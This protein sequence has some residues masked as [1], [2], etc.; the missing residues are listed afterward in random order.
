M[1][2]DKKWSASSCSVM[3]FRMRKTK[4]LCSTRILRSPVQL[5]RADTKWSPPSSSS[6]WS[7]SINPLITECDRVYS[8][9]SNLADPLTTIKSTPNTTNTRS[10]R[11][12]WLPHAG[13][14]DALGCAREKQAIIVAMMQFYRWRYADKL[15][16]K[17]CPQVEH[18]VDSRHAEEEVP[19]VVGS[20]VGIALQQTRNENVRLVRYR[21]RLEAH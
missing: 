13:A 5:R 20:V 4:S 8:I 7:M 3:Q 15:L 12:Q 14:D 9:N 10:L 1:N 18:N 11:C 17:T 6:S 19:M 2:S 16:W 21:G